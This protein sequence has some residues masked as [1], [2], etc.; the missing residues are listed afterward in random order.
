MSACC[1]ISH[2]KPEGYVAPA[3]TATAGPG[4]ASGSGWRHGSGAKR[5]EGMTEPAKL[6]TAIALGGYF[7]DDLVHPSETYVARPLSI[8]SLQ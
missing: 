2:P 8:S 7:A 3:P 5:A 4:A 1:T 6:G